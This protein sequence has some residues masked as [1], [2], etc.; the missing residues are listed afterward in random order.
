MGRLAWGALSK[1]PLLTTR[2]GTYARDV[3]LKTSLIRD[4]FIAEEPYMSHCILRAKATLL[5]F[6]IIHSDAN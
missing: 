5:V 1:Y 6:H 3:G 2:K 4:A